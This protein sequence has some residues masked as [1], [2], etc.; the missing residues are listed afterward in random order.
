MILD[1]LNNAH[2]YHG[3]GPRFVKAFE[4]LATT[5]FNTLEKGR[6]E[7]DGANIF[8]IV[9]EYDTVDA[10]GEQMEAHRKHIDVQ[11]LV[12]GEE[13]I[14]HDFL[15]QQVPSKA[16]SEEED[17]MLFAEKPAFFTKLMPHYFAIFFPTDLHMPNLTAEKTTAVKKVVIKISVQ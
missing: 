14:G 12:K 3:L 6:Y 15:Q 4:Y 7:I 9:N 2:L 11:Y 16:Y 17:Y 13:L 10:S 5:D 8:A 1:T